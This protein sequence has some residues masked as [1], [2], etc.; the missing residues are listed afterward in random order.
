VVPQEEDFQVILVVAIVSQ[1][2]VVVEAAQDIG[3][4]VQG[5]GVAVWCI[6]QGPIA[7][8]IALSIMAAHIKDITV[9]TEAEGVITWIVQSDT[10]ECYY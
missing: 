10:A 5:I 6:L 8:V 4:T 9:Y 7:G 2:M 3:V 1:V